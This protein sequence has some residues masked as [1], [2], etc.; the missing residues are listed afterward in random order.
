MAF[1][2]LLSVVS[3]DHGFVT[4]RRGLFIYIGGARRIGWVQCTEEEQNV[5]GGG[6]DTSRNTRRDL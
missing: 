1:V 5:A 3:F 6:T 4:I 2:V